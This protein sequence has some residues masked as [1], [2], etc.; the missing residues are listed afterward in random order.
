MIVEGLSS[1]SMTE[2]REEGVVF[3]GLVHWTEKMTKTG[4]DATECDQTISC[5]CPLL[6]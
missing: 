2:R 1:L 6:W 3:K 5:G 4:L